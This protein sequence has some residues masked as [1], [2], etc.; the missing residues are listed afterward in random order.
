M[1]DLSL[2]DISGME[3]ARR[4]TRRCPEVKIIALTVHEDRAYIHPVLE[5][6]RED[7]S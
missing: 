3:L 6:G 5:Q 7:I 1:I 2:P 4:V